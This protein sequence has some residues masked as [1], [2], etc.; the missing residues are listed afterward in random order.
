ML[1]LTL[2]L[3]LA[4]SAAAQ[5]QTANQRAETEAIRYLSPCHQPSEERQGLCEQNQ[6]NFVEEYVLGKSGDISGMGSTALS[7]M[8]AWNDQDRQSKIGMPQDQLQAC[9][10]RLVIAQLQRG[11]DSAWSAN[12]LAQTACSPLSATRVASAEERADHL[13]QELQ[14]S[15]AAA[16]SDDWCAH[17]PWIKVDCSEPA[18]H[19]PLTTTVTPLKAN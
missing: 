8:P 16:P 11:T 3:L 18:T 10:W 6:L 2:A 14:S 9:A 1:R 7:F 5:A 4:G 17:I 12:Q 13:A 19:G 15:P